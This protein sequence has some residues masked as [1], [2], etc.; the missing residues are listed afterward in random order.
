[1]ATKK[2]P[3][4][5]TFSELLALYADFLIVSVHTILHERNVYPRESFSLARK[6]NYPVR[7]SRH[8]QVCDWIRKS[9]SACMEYLKKGDVAKISVVILSLSNVPL[10]RFVFDVTS[11]PKVPIRDHDLEIENLILSTEDIEEQFRTCVMK[12]NYVSS[13]LG[14]LPDDCSF[15]ITIELT[16]DATAPVEHDSP[17]VPADDQP[18]GS[19]EQSSSNRVGIPPKIK[20]LR[21]VLMGPLSFDI[22]IEESKAKEKLTQ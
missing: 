7:Q 21:N 16:E 15:T 8:P 2:T 10:E 17:W 9:I 1:M 6:Y 18:I 3:V 5:W 19:N 11:F 22:W 12:L 14:K 20:P 13:T 4:A